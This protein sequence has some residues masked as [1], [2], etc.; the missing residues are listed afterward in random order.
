MEV[1]LAER[2][3]AHGV[4]R[5]KLV[6]RGRRRS[7]I[8]VLGVHMAKQKHAHAAVHELVSGSFFTN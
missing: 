1:D 6:C 2:E 5:T 8:M 4:K 3:A 7:K